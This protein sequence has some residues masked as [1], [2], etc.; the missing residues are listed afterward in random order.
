MAV[1]VNSNR[2]SLQCEK[3]LAIFAAVQMRID[4]RRRTIIELNFLCVKL[5]YKFRRPFYSVHSD[6]LHLLF[7]NRFSVAGSAR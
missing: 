3:F 2:S 4:C 5:R 1:H 7:Y 6:R